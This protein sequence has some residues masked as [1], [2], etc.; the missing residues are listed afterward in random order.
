MMLIQQTQKLNPKHEKAFLAVTVHT[1][2]VLCF[3]CVKT[4]FNL[5]FHNR[6]MKKEHRLCS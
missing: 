6:N 2:G 4:K 3:V 5:Q 1:E